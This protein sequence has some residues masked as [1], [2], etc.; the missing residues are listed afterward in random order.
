MFAMIIRYKVLYFGNSR[1]LAN[2]F[3][4]NAN[5]EVMRVQ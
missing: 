5:V 4:Q 1:R 3:E 2:S